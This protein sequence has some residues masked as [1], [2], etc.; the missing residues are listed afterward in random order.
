MEKMNEVKSVAKEP[1][2]RVNRRWQD[3]QCNCI[4][5]HLYQISGHAHL[6][7]FTSLREALKVRSDCFFTKRW[8]CRFILHQ[9]CISVF[10]HTALGSSG[11]EADIEAEPSGGT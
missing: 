3:N 5:E 4:R 10:Q 11:L 1:F 8:K 7:L 6:P 2:C 9:E